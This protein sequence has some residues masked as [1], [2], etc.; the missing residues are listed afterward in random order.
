M[1]W[2]AFSLPVTFVPNGSDRFLLRLLKKYGSAV[3]T[4]TG[5]PDH[6]EAGRITRSDDGKLRETAGYGHRNGFTRRIVI[7]R[8]EPVERDH[9]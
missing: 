5:R 2:S 4:V 1:K 3:A 7:E 8:V 6:E 9:R